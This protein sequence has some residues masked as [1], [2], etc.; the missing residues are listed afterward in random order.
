MNPLIR[1]PA[2][3]AKVLTN[4]APNGHATARARIQLKLAALAVKASGEIASKDDR[5]TAELERAAIR[6]LHDASFSYVG[7]LVGPDLSRDGDAA[8]ARAAMVG[9][10]LAVHTYNATRIGR[11][12]NTEFCRAGV[13][14]LCS[15]AIAYVEAVTGRDRPGLV[16][17]DKSL[18]L[19]GA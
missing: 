13:A 12:A 17:L 8:H 19:E 16:G 7:A 6:M 14:M 15:A 1:R 10:E 18:A 9:L 4:H 11:D 3:A 5:R 2:Q